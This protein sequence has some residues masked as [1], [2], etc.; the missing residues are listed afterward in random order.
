MTKKLIVIVSIT[1]CVLTTLSIAEE[2]ILL[3]ALN[4]MERVEQNGLFKGKGHAEIKSAQNEVESF[5][6]IVSAPSD[7]LVIT[8]VEISDLHGKNGALLSKDRIKLFREEYVRVWR[9]SPRPEL[10]PGLYADPLVP[11]INPLTGKPIVHKQQYRERW[12]EPIKTIGHE[13][14]AMP[15][16]VFS[17]QNQP[18][19]F[20]VSVPD[21]TEPGVYTGKVTVTSENDISQT[22]E[23]SLTV[24]DFALP[25]TATMRTHFGTIP[26]ADTYWKLG[27]NSE[28]FRNIEMNYCDVFTEHR[29]TPP[30]PRSLLPQATDD[31][32]LTITPERHAKL[33]EFLKK[34]RISEFEIPRIRYKKPLTDDR[35]KIVRYLSDY[36]NYLKENGWAEG[37]FYYMHDEPNLPENYEHVSEY[38][39]LVNEIA[40]GLKRLVVEQT[41]KEAPSWP[42][43]DHAIDIWCPL[44]SFIHRESILEKVAHG[45]EV[46]S[47]SA[48]TQ[49]APDYHPNYD[50]VKDLDPPYWHIDR[51]LAN[52]RAPM[53]INWQYNIT[54]LLYWTSVAANLDQ[55]NI[56]AFTSF[57]RYLN[58]GGY[59]LYPGYPCGMDTAV[60]CIRLKNV[61]DGIEDFE[62]FAILE[63]IAGRDAVD[64]FVD[65]IAPNWWEFSKD[66]GDYSRA[67]ELIA[68]EIVR[69]K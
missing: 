14:Y 46:W 56:P 2:R 21:D 38:G 22:I 31:G 16:P 47:Y 8:N 6:I 3:S 65:R 62:Y 55:W 44:W 7:H 37:A 36:M 5:Q 39:K 19:W 25:D 45:D 10:P 24:W 17:G 53:W 34:H 60:S 18:I 50:K 27:V 48:L 54:G 61:R 43:I 26:H 64:K 58:G 29:L 30:I 63:K 59:L 1:L 57:G 52:Y 67:R 41:Y 51:P 23:V 40:P 9:A 49:R 66:S 11:F 32:S 33:K 20:D 28:R 42:E 13:M 68:E 69:L 15:F 35:E 4:S 12:G